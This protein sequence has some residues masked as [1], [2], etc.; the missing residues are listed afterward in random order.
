MQKTRSILAALAV[1][2]FTPALWAAAPLDQYTVATDTVKDNKTGLTWQ[3][4]VPATRYPWADAK[5]YCSS[6]NLGGYAS[7]WR[8]PTKR[9]L[10]TL[11]DHRSDYGYPTIDTTAFPG[12]PQ[13]VFWTSTPFAGVSSKAWCVSFQSTWGTA[14]GS[15]S[16]GSLYVRCVR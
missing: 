8:L 16:A 10:E 7:G 3:R 1:L 9:E 6:L 11:I 14:L 13:D 5:T 4:A 12:T 15:D 2:A